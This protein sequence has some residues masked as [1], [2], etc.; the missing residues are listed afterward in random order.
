MKQGAQPRRIVPGTDATYDEL[1]ITQL[2]PLNFAEPIPAKI[3][4]FVPQY[5]AELNK[6]VFATVTRQS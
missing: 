6:G 4:D 1:A 2:R 3:A 5:P